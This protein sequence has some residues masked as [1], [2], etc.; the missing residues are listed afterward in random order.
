MPD[1]VDKL[2]KSRGWKIELNSPTTQSSEI[3]L[4]R[5]SVQSHVEINPF[6]IDKSGFP[7]AVNNRFR[8]YHVRDS[9]RNEVRNEASWLVIKRLCQYAK[10]AKVLVIVTAETTME[11]E[12]LSQFRSPPKQHVARVGAYCGKP[13]TARG[14][15]L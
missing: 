15:H 12:I 8:N 1:T 11:Q 10:S 3:C 6:P 4:K 5:R 14:D 13:V 7:S 2:D 9:V